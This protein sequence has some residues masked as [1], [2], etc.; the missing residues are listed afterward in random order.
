[1]EVLP[2]PT[3]TPRSPASATDEQFSQG[4]KR[5]FAEFSE[6]SE[7][8]QEQPQQEE[9]VLES[10]EKKVKLTEETPV[11][12]TEE[13]KVVE[14]S[15]K[16]LE[17]STKPAEETPVTEESEPVKVAAPTE[18]VVAEESSKSEDAV[19]EQ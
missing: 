6:E 18:N 13:S 15:Q 9:K 1:M 5:T 16:A 14:D 8:V 3:V 11:V 2:S 19:A 10:P 12:P 17:S 7:V 4:H